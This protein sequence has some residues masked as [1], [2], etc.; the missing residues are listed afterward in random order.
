MT[1]PF[2]PWR[3][4]VSQISE[5]HT[6]NNQILSVRARE[7]TG[8]IAIPLARV[9]F[10]QNEVEMVSRIHPENQQSRPQPKKFE[11]AEFYLTERQA[12]TKLGVSQK[13]LQAWRLRGG[14]PA[15]VKISAR[16]VRYRESV[17]DAWALA[18]ER[19]STTDTGGRDL[20]G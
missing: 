15:F 7:L 12:A 17:I 11:F 6:T 5:S 16:C 2:D 1:G 13:T 20:D 4:P 9:V 19:E 8:G 3:L 10:A 18:R 14:G